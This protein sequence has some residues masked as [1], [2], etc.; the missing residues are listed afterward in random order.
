MTVPHLLHTCALPPAPTQ[1]RGL[2]GSLIPPAP[3]Y[4]FHWVE[5]KPFD[6]GTTTRKAMWVTPQKGQSLSEAMRNSARLHCTGSQSNGSLMRCVP[7]AIWCAI[8]STWAVCVCCLVCWC[9][10][11]FVC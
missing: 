7:L 11:V 1:L 3:S 2:S 6:I 5:S 9:V 4:Y 10:S 8:V